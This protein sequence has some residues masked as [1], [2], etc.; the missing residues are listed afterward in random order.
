M[1]DLINLKNDKSDRRVENMMM[2][3]FN[4]IKENN[5]D[6]VVIEDVAL[7]KNPATLIML[8]RLQGA[9]IGFCEFNGIPYEIMKPPSWRKILGFKQGKG[10]E[11]LDLKKQAIEYV[12]NKYSL[13]LQ[14][15]VCES[16]C[17]GDACRIS[18]EL[19]ERCKNNGK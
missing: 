19:K 13:K 18:M 14:D 15:D 5:P 16:I 10:E 3:I 1:Y 7:Q 11:R 6:Y 8:S 4:C 12:Q 2:R 17:I 9:I